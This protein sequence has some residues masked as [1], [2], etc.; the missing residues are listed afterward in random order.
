MT[1]ITRGTLVSV[2]LLALA[3]AGC[4]GSSQAP[5]TDDPEG[6]KTPA[7]D[8]EGAPGDGLGDEPTKSEQEGRLEPGDPET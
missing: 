1:Q 4:D 3:V 6:H 2:T 5:I 8:P 7:E